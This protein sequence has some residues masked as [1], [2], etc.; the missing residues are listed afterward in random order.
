MF[1]ITI[2]SVGS[3]KQKY[4]IEGIDL[5]STRLR[6]YAKIK[7]DS[8]R[9]ESFA[10]STK[11]QAKRL[12]GERIVKYLAKYDDCEIIVL[13]E[14]G[15]QYT[16]VSFSRELGNTQ[17]HIV[18]VI[19]GSLGLSEEVLKKYPRHLSL[20]QMTFTHEMTLVILLEQVYRA[21]TIMKG[22]EYHH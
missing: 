16:S 7:I 17:K 1:Y 10:S 20:S 5:Y 15:K 3:I 6:P 12:E 2:V 14:K 19:G 8:I 4:L 18:F 22:K 9:E 21:I 13:D 11:E